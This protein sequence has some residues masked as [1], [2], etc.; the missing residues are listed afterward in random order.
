VVIGETGSGKTTQMTQYLAEVRGWL[1]GWLGGWLATP[2]RT[3]FPT[4]K[5]NQ[6]QT[7]HLTNQP[8]PTPTPIPNPPTPHQIGFTSKGKLGCTQPRRVAAM[9]IA[10]RVAEEFGCRLGEEVRYRGLGRFGFGLV[11]LGR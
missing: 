6:A 9:S 2:N 3:P 1:D 10:K 8:T 4:V 7:P 5:H 11:R